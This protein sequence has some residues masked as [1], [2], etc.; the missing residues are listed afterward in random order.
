MTVPGKVVERLPKWLRGNSEFSGL[1]RNRVYKY[2]LRLINKGRNGLLRLARDNESILYNTV[3]L[4]R[5]KNFIPRKVDGSVDSAPYPT[6]LESAARKDF[7]AMLT[8]KEHLYPRP[9][10]DEYKDLEGI[11]PRSIQLS[12][13]YWENAGKYGANDSRKLR[14]WL[15]KWMSKDEIFSI[16]DKLIFNFFDAPGVT[17]ELM[18]KDFGWVTHVK[19][20]TNEGYTPGGGLQKQ[21]KQ[22]VW[23]IR[24][25]TAKLYDRWEKD[26]DS[27]DWEKFA[28]MPSIRMERKKKQ[29]LVAMVAKFFKPSGAIISYLTKKR[30]HLLGLKIPRI[31]GDLNNLAKKLRQAKVGTKHNFLGKDFNAYDANLPLLLFLIL[32]E[33]LRER[34]Y[35]EV[36]KRWANFF[37]GLFAMELD[38]VIHAVLI[39]GPNLVFKLNSLPSGIGITQLLGSIIHALVDEMVGLV[40]LLVYYQSDDTGGVTK[41]S[42]SEIKHAFHLLNDHFKMPVSELGEKSYYGDVLKILQMWIYENFDFGDEKRR[43]TNV[44]FP[45]RLSKENFEMLAQALRLNKNNEKDVRR[46]RRYNKAM[47]LLGNLNSL[48]LKAP[49]LPDYLASVW[50]KKNNGFTW[51]TI[52][53]VLPLLGYEPNDVFIKMNYNSKIFSQMI[54]EAYLAYGW[55]DVTA[56]EMEFVT[57]KYSV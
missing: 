12:L 25:Q 47:S 49:M 52:A 24:W 5:Y 21:T 10:L 40:F 20:D 37:V 28:F 32:M 38:L 33:Y 46:L 43:W 30:I 22:G 6:E 1:P 7:V 54:D 45:E 14:A 48:G 51:T 4:N 57:T 15:K 16:L 27:I 31:E 2:N 56:K 3:A 53:T 44:L 19:S 9:I 29:R 8:P 23:D 34:F 42:E 55:R 41:N 35:D 18:M 26:P 11:S 36:K 17:M 13:P 50:G 39:V